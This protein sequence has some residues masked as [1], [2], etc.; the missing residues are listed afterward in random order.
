MKQKLELV[1]GSGNVSGDFGHDNADAEQFKAIRR[2]VDFGLFLRSP[3]PLFAISHFH[4][5]FPRKTP[6]AAAHVKKL[7]MGRWLVRRGWLTWRS[8][9]A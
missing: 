8:E 1:R 9:E 7:A 2:A 4:L 6:R 3:D 5:L